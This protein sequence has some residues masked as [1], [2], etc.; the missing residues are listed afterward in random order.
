M[1]FLGS[2]ACHEECGARI[3]D[4]LERGGDGSERAIA[5]DS[6]NLGN[7]EVAKGRWAEVMDDTRVLAGNHTDWGSK[8]CV[9]YQHFVI[10]PDPKDA[11]DIDT[12]RSLTME[13]AHEFFGSEMEPGRLGSYEVAVVYHDDNAKGIP[14]AHVIVNNT[15]LDNGKRLQINRSDSRLLADRLQEMCKKRGLSFFGEGDDAPNRDQGRYFTKQER[16]IIRDGHY[17]WKQDIANNV[18]VARRVCH[19]EGEFIDTCKRLGIRAEARPDGDFLYTHYHNEARWKVTGYRLGKNYTRESIVAAL[20][21]NAEEYGDA[22]V[23]VRRNV[24]RHVVEDLFEGMEMAAVVSHAE[25]VTDVAFA[26]QVNDRYQ[27]RSMKDYD[28]RIAMHSALLASARP[29]ERADKL[30]KTVS[31]LVRARESARRGRYF[32][33]ARLGR[34]RLDMYAVG[35]GAGSSGNGSNIGERA[36]GQSGRS[37]SI[38]AS[39]QQENVKAPNMQR[40]RSR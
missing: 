19:E 21:K 18:T 26:L 6:I 33:G 34:P 24:C 15:N 11:V 10:S 32:E 17:S 20:E 8:R 29:G 37:Q 25:S 3:M 7:S 40:P 22:L 38:S 4:Y 36:Y 30:H 39:R 9:T 16:K 35:K 1:A 31:D 23:Q 13:W 28:R 27:I 5:F 12:L 14:H 2:K